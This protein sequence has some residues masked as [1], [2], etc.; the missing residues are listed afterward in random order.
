MRFG[1]AQSRKFGTDLGS[2]SV[3]TSRERIDSQITLT[4]YES[5]LLCSHFGVE[6]IHVGNVAQA[7][8]R[9]AKSFR[10]YPSGGFIQLNVVFPKPEKA[11]LRLY[12]SEKSGFRP[13]SEYVWFLFTLDKDIWI[14]AMPEPVWRLECS[15]LRK[16]DTDY[17]YQESL[18]LDSE[19]RIS[20]SK[21]RDIFVR[22]RRI[23]LQRMQLSDYRCEYN[24]SH[25]LFVSRFS[26]KEYLEAHH[27]IPMS[28]QGGFSEPLDSLF[29]VFCLC[30]G[31][32]RAVHHAEEGLAR[33][34]LQ[35][36]AGTRDVLNKYNLGIEDLY[37]LYSVEEII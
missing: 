11:E 16:D 31:C 12:L 2:Y 33:E 28:L 10:L 37:S 18:E 21:A 13:A 29:N 20:T 3:V 27:L 23:A 8:D 17:A 14:G 9:A 36:L 22:D 4:D 19:I 1:I 7:P 5:K 26:R 34:I 32:H 15:E 35:T 6:N 30:P 24:A 25:S